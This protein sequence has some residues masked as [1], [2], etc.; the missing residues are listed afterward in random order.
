MSTFAE[1]TRIDAPLGA[2][3]AVLDNIGS[4]AEWNPGLIGSETITAAANGVRAE[5]R[6]TI[7]SRHWLEA[8]VLEHE[9]ERLTT[10]RVVRSNLPFRSADIRFTVEPASEHTVVNV[11]PTY[12]LKYGIVGTLLD[13][14][15]VRM[16]YRKAMR[17]LLTGLKR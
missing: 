16:A 8:R 13:G 12:R 10:F 6:C 9:P 2:V 15:G 14:A 5:R 3:W 1:S 17:S 7:S 4:I 11:A